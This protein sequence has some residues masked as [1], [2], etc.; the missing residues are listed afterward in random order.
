MEFQFAFKN[1]LEKLKCYP[2][3]FR[4]FVE[5]H[6]IGIKNANP[7]LPVLIRECSGIQPKLFARFGKYT[8]RLTL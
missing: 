3:H 7:D 4:D 6:Y 1:S 8:T 5:Q 2:L